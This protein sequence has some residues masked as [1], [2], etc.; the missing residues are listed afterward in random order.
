MAA[1]LALAEGKKDD[2]VAL[3]QEAVK[4]EESMRPPNGAA[5]PV[6]PRHG[7]TDEVLR[8]IGNLSWLRIRRPP[9]GPARRPRK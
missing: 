7:P 6:K 2:A 4:L 8:E 5:D 9:R 1:L 3:L